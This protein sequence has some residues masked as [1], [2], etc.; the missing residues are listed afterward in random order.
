MYAVRDTQDSAL[1]SDEETRGA[2]I[3]RRLTDLGVGYREFEERSGI[4]RKTLGRAIHDDPTVRENTYNLIED[5]LT[6]TEAAN[7][8]PA[9]EGDGADIVEFRLTGN[10]GVDVVVK[11]PIRD[12]RALEESVARLLR[13]MRGP[14]H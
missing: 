6:A 12:Q 5:W 1:V 11:G 2:A 4:N 14:G 8:G 7:R 13:E 3:D 9:D 10:F